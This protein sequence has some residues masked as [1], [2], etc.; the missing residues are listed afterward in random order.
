MTT[1]NPQQPSNLNTSGTNPTTR[2][3]NNFYT[4]N[5]GISPGINDAML[6]FFEQQTGNV[7]SAKLLAQSV[8]D[9]AKA[10]KEDPLIVLEQFQKL[11]TG[12]LNT[13]LSLYLNTSRVN[14]SL[15][16][17]TNSPRASEYVT[18]TIIDF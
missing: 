16:G 7:E 5:T 8:I 15:L 12:Q 9:T 3:F 10:N 2:Y 6:S 13:I 1:F 14:T 4:D 11:N 17:I 18:R